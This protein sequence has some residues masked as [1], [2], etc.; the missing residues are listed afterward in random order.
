MPTADRRA[1]LRAS[2]W[3]LPAVA[4]ATSSPAYAAS[5]S[6]NLIAVISGP[7]EPPASTAPQ[8]AGLRTLTFRATF[9]N[10]SDIQIPVG[11]SIALSFGA[12]VFWQSPVV[13][14]N[15]GGIA[16][17]DPPVLSW[18]TQT[19]GTATG[20][21]KTFTY[22]VQQAIAARR[23]FTLTFTITLRA[24]PATTDPDRWSNPDNLNVNMRAR[25][26]WQLPGGSGLV[27][28]NSADNR[29]FTQYFTVDTSV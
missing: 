22:T 27:E 12:G 17:S 5:P 9:T 7:A 8:Y 18:E 21:R 10:D 16:L 3:S 13:A 23:A 29:G 6:V 2:A 15:P 14:A 25:I 26:D 4:V 24:A 19:F 11:S 20:D 28:T 1:V